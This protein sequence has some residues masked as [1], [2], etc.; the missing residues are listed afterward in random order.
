MINSVASLVGFAATS[1]TYSRKYEYLWIFVGVTLMAISYLIIG[2]APFIPVEPSYVL[3]CTAQV[4]R[5]LGF[6]PLLICTYSHA[7]R[8]AVEEEEHPDNVKTRSFVSAALELLS[9]IISIPMGPL[10]GLLASTL[11]FRKASM[12]MFGLLATWAVIS[13]IIWIGRGPLCCRT[14]R[15]QSEAG[16]ETD[17]LVSITDHPHV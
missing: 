1:S 10:A 11:G 3:I 5:G 4:L 2:P 13:G 14:K 16:R 6:S 9:T 7:M 12:C 17:R 8:I 15:N